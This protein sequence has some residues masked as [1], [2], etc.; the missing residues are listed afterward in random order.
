[1]Q[2]RLVDFVASLRDGGVTIGLI[3]LSHVPDLGR[4]PSNNKAD[5]APAGLLA[6]L[7]REFGAGM[8]VGL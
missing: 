2:V 4:Q 7:A 3:I 1:M 8:E 6:G 5:S